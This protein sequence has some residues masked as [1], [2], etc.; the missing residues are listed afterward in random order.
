MIRARRVAAAALLPLV[1]A[2]GAATGAPGD[3]GYLEIGLA[4]LV[5]REILA[6]LDGEPVG[7]AEPAPAVTL[8]GA[9]YRG[10]AFVEGR[11][12]GLDGVSLGATLL[13]TESRALELLAVHLPGSV[14][15]LGYT[16]ADASPNV[17]A[18]DRSRAASLFSRNTLFGT[19][20]LRYREYRGDLLL[21][22][23]AALAWKHGNGVLLGAHAARRWQLGRWSLEGAVGLRFASAALVDF[24]YGIDPDEATARF[25]AYRA[26]GAPFGEAAL[27]ITRAL[28]RDVVL[29]A[30]TRARRFGDGVTD[31]PLVA[32]G[33]SL[34]AEA[35]VAYVF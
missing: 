30:T 23:S 25:P 32:R 8:A 10:R 22:G 21:Q 1:L 5:E 4:A 17:D 2:W 31:S 34:Y 20:G 19:S 28:G 35:G 15:E 3:G 18:D 12:G 7:W 11:R 6:D 26:P 33:T 9:W 27:G 13:G 24:L 14:E 29:R 16:S